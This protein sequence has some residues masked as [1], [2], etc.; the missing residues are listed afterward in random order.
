[1]FQ[2]RA[3]EPDVNDAFRYFRVFALAGL[4]FA[5]VVI[6]MRG[7]IGWTFA[8]TADAWPAED[9]HLRL[10]IDESQ[11]AKYDHEPNE[12]GQFQAQYEKL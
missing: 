1:M 11:S 2:Q 6:G 9:R 7:A 4:M 5:A 3:R 10:S 8:D 12:D